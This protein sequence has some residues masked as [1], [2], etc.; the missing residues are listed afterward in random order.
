MEIQTLITLY[1]YSLYCLSFT[2][3]GIY[4]PIVYSSSS[5]VCRVERFAHAVSL[6]LYRQNTSLRP[7]KCKKPTVCSMIIVMVNKT[8]GGE[9]KSPRKR[10]KKKKKEWPVVCNTYKLLPILYNGFKVLI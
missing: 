8:G 1:E 6:P 10:E 5:V 4:E 3:T 7:M 2:L 9:K